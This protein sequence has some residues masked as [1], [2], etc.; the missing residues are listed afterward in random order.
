M[1]T[2]YQNLSLQGFKQFGTLRDVLGDK[3]LS[4]FNLIEIF[5]HNW[6]KRIVFEANNTK[7][8]DAISPYVT[9]IQNAG[10]VL[11][12]AIE[13]DNFFKRNFEKENNGQSELQH[14]V[15]F[16]CGIS[17]YHSTTDLHHAQYSSVFGFI[18]NLIVKYCGKPLNSLLSNGSSK[19]S[20]KILTKTKSDLVI[21][22]N[23]FEKVYINKKLEVFAKSKEDIELFRLEWNDFIV[24]L[25]TI[26]ILK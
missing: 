19:S 25:M 18:N 17:D 6:P 10:V 20:I 9:T 1:S 14:A 16:C 11:H 24:T 5:D 26:G 22:K 12:I 15:S 8:N 3:Q 21:D 23:L 13:F 2:T 7:F 4:R